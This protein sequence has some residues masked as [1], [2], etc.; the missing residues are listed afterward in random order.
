MAARRNPAAPSDRQVLHEWWPTLT[1]PGF[2]ALPPPGVGRQRAQEAVAEAA[3]TAAAQ[4]LPAGTSFACWLASGTAVFTRAG[5]LAGPLPLHWGG[6]H[7]LVRAAL[8]TPPAG[9]AVTDGGPGAVFAFDRQTA[10]DA[11]GLPFPDDRAGVRQFLAGLRPE[12][13]LTGAEAAWLHDRLNDLSDLEAIAPFIRALDDRELLTPDELDRLLAARRAAGRP[14]YLRGRR[15]LLR[16][17]L[18]AEHPEA[19]NLAD[20]DGPDAAHALAEVPSERGLQTVRSLV[21]NTGD[22]R[23][24]DPWLR[25]RRALHERDLAEAAAAIAAEISGDDH[26]VRALVRA[27]RA[28]LVAESAPDGDVEAAGK[29]ASLRL[30]LDERLPR[31]ARV[32]AAHMTR[33]WIDR[34]WPRPSEE[35]G[36]DIGRFES[37]AGDLLS[38]TGP[39]LTA[40]DANLGDIW[41]RYRRLSPDEAGRLKA[42]IADPSTDQKGVAVSLEL[43]YAH[44]MATAA[45]ADALAGRWK[46]L[47]AKTY[48]TTYTEWRHPMVTLTCLA[49]DLGH[50]LAEELEKWWVKPAPKWK[51]ALRPLTWLGAPG[52]D[53][54]ARLWSYATSGAHDSG[55]LLTWVLMRARLDGV[56][57]RQVAAGLVGRPDLREHV[58]KRVLVGAA[59]PAQPLWHYDVDPRSWSWWL[60]AVELAEG[61]ELPSAARALARKVA[62]EHYLLR[63]PD[64]VAPRPTAAEIVAA[65][66]WVE[67][68]G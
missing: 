56:P 12:V 37:L 65:V 23:A 40:S 67:G 68:E 30:A 45:E 61:A 26:M 24:V 39:D 19:W 47:L 15:A 33:E 11:E 55:H 22:V 3:R 31:E 7:A 32:H 59:D 54:A 1:A 18:R 46:S 64:Q 25:I 29:S 38:G 10:R 5:A 48:R 6:D 9:Y 53:T 8:G 43:L 35:F 17:L 51:D 58:L 2:L 16:A 4:G 66:R 62:G 20:E 14:G 36:A 13:P 44:G 52:E 63:Y 49:R 28:V 41:H 42:R 50:P 57:P 34:L 60:R 27:T 21:L